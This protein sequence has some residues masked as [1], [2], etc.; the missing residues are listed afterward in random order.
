M[1]SKMKKSEFKAL[2]FEFLCEALQD[3]ARKAIQEGDLRKKN[4]P[5]P[6]I[7]EEGETLPDNVDIM[8]NKFPTLKHCLIRLQTENFRE[9]VSGIDW[10]S[11]KPTEFRVNLTNGQSFNLKWMGKDFEATISG[12][13]Y[14][15]GELINFQRALEKLSILYQEGPVAPEGNQDFSGD[16]RGK[17][18]YTSGGGGGNFPGSEGPGGD[19]SEPGP[20]PEGGEA[21]EPSSE[22]GGEEPEEDM[23]SQEVDFEGGEL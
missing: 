3:R 17:D 13:K 19:F 16:S 20:E 9:F 10:V 15:L 6:V 1:E 23:S 2:I 7:N 22:G 8:L 14:Y 4:T 18:D 5:D 11:P 21:P 12:K